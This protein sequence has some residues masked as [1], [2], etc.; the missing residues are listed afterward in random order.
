MYQKI[1]KSKN[2]GKI[3]DT[4]GLPKLKQDKMNNLNRYYKGSK[5]HMDSLLNPQHL[6]KN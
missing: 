5:V 6:K 3:I 4:Y 1:I 2:I